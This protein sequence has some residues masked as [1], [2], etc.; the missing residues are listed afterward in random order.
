MFM[1]DKQHHTKYAAAAFRL[2]EK[3]KFHADL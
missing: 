3:K 2:G 1:V